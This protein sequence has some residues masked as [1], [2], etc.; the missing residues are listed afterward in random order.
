[1]KQF[2]A[3]VF[4]HLRVTEGL[5]AAAKGAL[6]TFVNQVLLIFVFLQGVI[7]SGGRCW[8][9]DRRKKSWSP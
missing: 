9:C 1:V 4:D 6:S 7:L 8:L 3:I 5:Q 2:M